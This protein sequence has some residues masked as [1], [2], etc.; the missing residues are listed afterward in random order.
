MLVLV[1]YATNV[2]NLQLA[3]HI[4]ILLKQAQKV[5]PFLVKSELLSQLLF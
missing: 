1:A 5:R 4:V 3:R 2:S